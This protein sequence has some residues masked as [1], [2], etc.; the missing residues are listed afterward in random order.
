[1]PTIRIS[2]KSM[3][4][5][6]AWAEPL[7]DTADSALAKVLDV[8]ERYRGTR[9]RVEAD[10]SQE[11]RESGSR[12]PKTPLDAFR[13]PLVEVIYNRGGS[14]RRSELRVLMLERMKP[15]LIPGDFDHDT[16]GEERWWKSI[17]W[18]ALPL[19][20]RRLSQRRYATRRVG[21][22]REG[23]RPRREPAQG[24]LKQHRRSPPRHAGCWGRFRL[25]PLVVVT[26]NVR[27]IAP[28]GARCLDPFG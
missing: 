10:H 25:R 8:A 23:G 13:E 15:Q 6:K 19:G 26:R 11:P 17:D 16:S 14:A 7:E 21:L 20:S 24:N 9:S 12:R 3:Q 22:V 5:L 18:D 1:M 4:R 27:H 2:D 28:T